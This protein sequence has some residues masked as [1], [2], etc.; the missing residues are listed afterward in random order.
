MI[1]QLHKN[2]RGFTLIE[3]I[4][5]IAILLV[6]VTIAV[7]KFMGQ[8]KKATTA[9]HIANAKTLENAVGIYNIEK[10][11]FPRLSETPYTDVQIKAYAKSIKDLTGEEA[12]LDPTGNYYD[13][14]YVALKDYVKIPNDSDKGNYI[15]QNPVGKIFYLEDLTEEAKTR[16]DFTTTN[17]ENSEKAN[18]AAPTG[19]TKID[20]HYCMMGIGQIVGVKLGQEYRK[21]GGA[22]ITITSNNPLK[23]LSMGKYEVRWAK[24]GS[25]QASE[26][27]FITID[28]D[29][30]SN[31]GGGGG[32]V[33]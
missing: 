20:D 29:T 1:K 33:A 14:D 31:G 3:L 17:P 26:S 23:N 27:I 15:L 25:N 11:G 4:V 12:T 16:V 8:T 10:D 22:W 19:I 30:G 21:E 32:G 5:V 28:R 9:K 13:L 2:R 6:L 7:P 18:K 24:E